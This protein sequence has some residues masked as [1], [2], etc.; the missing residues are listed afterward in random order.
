M[1][2]CSRG[3]DEQGGIMRNADFGR[4]FFLA[5]LI[6][7]V[8]GCDSR[9]APSSAGEPT[10]YR[11][12]AARHRVWLLSG[13]GVLVDD[14]AASKRITVSLPEWQW[15]R[16]PWGCLPDLALGPD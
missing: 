11:V 14:A 4:L 16:P 2:I 1:P 9:A 6:V 8:A 15:L 5:V 13:E 7:P 10:R 3:A 12:D